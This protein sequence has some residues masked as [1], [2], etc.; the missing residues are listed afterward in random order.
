MPTP[1]PTTETPT[2]AF[3]EGSIRSFFEKE[4]PE[5]VDDASAP[6][7][8]PEPT[9]TPAVLPEGNLDEPVKP[10]G[11]TSLGDDIAALQQKK[12]DE[13]AVAAKVLA[14]AEAA[15]KAALPV[16]PVHQDLEDVEKNLDKHTKPS[17][18]KVISTFKGEAIA[19]RERANKAEQDRQAAIK[20]RDALQEQIKSGKPAPETEQ[21]LT[22]LRER[23][24]ELDASKDPAIEAK[25]DKPVQ[26]NTEA[27]IAMLGDYGFFKI[28]E[29]DKDGKGT[30]TYRDMSEKE[31][32][33][34]TNQL[35]AAGISLK[36]MAQHINRLE[37][38]GDYD[39][40][41]QLRALAQEN[42]RLG[43]DKATEI[44]TI[45]GNYEGRAQARTKEQQAQQEQIQSIA[46]T[47]SQKTLQADIAE[48]AKSF[49]AIAQPPEPLPTDSAAVVASKKATIAEY[50]AAAKQVEEAV[51]S[52]NGSGLPADKAAEAQGRMTASAV[53]AVILQQHVLPKMVKAAA[54]KDA[55]I[56]DL[57]AQVAKFR[58]A[59]GLNR[60]HA[61]SIS[62]GGAQQ[63]P[64]VPAN[65][66]F[67][68]SLREGLKAR[69]VDVTT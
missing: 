44:A 37:K 59:G 7:E 4:H 33:Q 43:R 64:A 39:G 36:T 6:A 3:D 14:D 66:S 52:F 34:A 28:A 68:D 49:P 48:L 46:T 54:E 56:K 50:T 2:L 24:R 65:A 32:T 13:D 12:T 35:K 47:T 5:L 18:R 30:G 9:E 27:A 8:T 17:T 21:E 15:K 22:T 69:G 20:E 55:R 63:V 23:L 29:T 25:Y 53:K 16:A 61:A 60:A 45:K 38:S 10:E 42:D 40:A 51:K 26:K 57:E 1:D 41:E 11:E 67:A 19:A 31:K 58:T 62:T